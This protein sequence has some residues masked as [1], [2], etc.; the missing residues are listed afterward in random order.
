MRRSNAVK[1]IL[2]AKRIFSVDFVKRT[3]GE[4]RRMVCRRGVTKHLKGGEPAYSFK[5]NDL[6]SVY[7]MEKQGYRS[8]PIEGIVGLSYSG[9][10]HAVK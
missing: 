2:G 3:T 7:D 6:I 10:Y 4:T 1:L 5:D 9:A 8:I